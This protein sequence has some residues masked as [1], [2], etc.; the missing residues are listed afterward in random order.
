MTKIFTI[1]LKQF[2]RAQTR[3]PREVVGDL[4]TLQKYFDY[5]LECGNSW[6]PKIKRQPK[7]IKSFVKN[8]QMSYEE[9]EASCYTRTLVEL[10]EEIKQDPISESISRFGVYPPPSVDEQLE[11]LEKMKAKTYEF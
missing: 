9:K 8:L 4:P 7:T 1:I 2:G 5:T 10:K 3:E 11:L 6:N